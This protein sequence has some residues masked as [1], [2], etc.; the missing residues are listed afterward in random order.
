M[1]TWVREA[2]D[3]IARLGPDVLLGRER[4]RA[5]RGHRDARCT[6]ARR[7]ALVGVAAPARR[8]ASVCDLD[9]NVCGSRRN[10]ETA[11]PLRVE[12]PA[13]PAGRRRVGALQV[14]RL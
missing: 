14:D 10:S 2:L 1:L 6:G 5:R 8:S 3:R 12:S 7:S 13:D 9:A 11:A 4:A